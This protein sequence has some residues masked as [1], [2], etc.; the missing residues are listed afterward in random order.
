MSRHGS[1]IV[2][3]KNAV[4]LCGDRQDVTV[5]DP[6]EPRDVCGQK[7]DGRFP[8]HTPRNDGVVEAGVRQEADRASAR[9]P[10]QLAS[11]AIQL[12]LQI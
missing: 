10:V 11:Y 12:L 3:H 9:R 6:F 2:C 8:S 4:G 5:R 1:E 7:I